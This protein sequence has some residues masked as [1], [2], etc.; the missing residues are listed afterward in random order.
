MLLGDGFKPAPAL[1]DYDGQMVVRAD[2]QCFL[3]STGGDAVLVHKV[4]RRTDPSASY[5]RRKKVH[6]DNGKLLHDGLHIATPKNGGNSITP[7]LAVEE[8]YAKEVAGASGSFTVQHRAAVVEGQ[9]QWHPARSGNL[10]QS[11]EKTRYCF[12]WPE[13]IRRDGLDQ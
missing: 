1:N 6:R 13:A 11:T 5:G 10:G 4:H 12:I 9:Q 8:A 7:M 3:Q 2:N